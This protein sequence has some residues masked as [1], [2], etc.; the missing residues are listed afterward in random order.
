[1]FHISSLFP[2]KDSI[3][4]LHRSSVVYRYTC[5]GCNAAYIGKTMH[6]L[7][8][9][10]DEHHGISSYTGKTL[11]TQTHSS[12]RNHCHQTGHPFTYD[13]FNIIS[14]ARSGFELF[15]KESLV[16]HTSKPDLNNTL[17]YFAIK[18]MKSICMKNHHLACT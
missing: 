10:A 13:A 5:S 11:Q 8:T 14:S 6:H 3:P 1:M 4:K 9:R 18:L 15:I 12:I 17:S 2:I 7:L 16:I